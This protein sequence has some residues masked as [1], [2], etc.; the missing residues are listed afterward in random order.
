MARP[1][2]LEFPG[3]LYHV[4]SR[5]HEKSS[6]FRDRRDRRTFLAILAAVIRRERWLLH[7]YCLLGNHYHL[8]LETPLGKL[9]RG[10]HALNALYSQRFNRRHERCGHLF[11]GRFKALHVEK[12]SHLL[13]LHRY[14][15][16]NPVRA[17]LVARPEE[18]VWSSYR[19]TCGQGIAPPWLEVEWTLAQF[20]RDRETA[21]NSY[22]RFV[23]SAVKKTSDPPVTGQVYVGSP[24]FVADIAR[25]LGP[26]TPDSEIPMVQQR[27]VPPTLDDVRSTV[28][29]EWNVPVHVLSRPRT[30]EPKVAAIYLAAKLTGLAKREIGGAFGVK[31]GRVSNVISEVERGRYTPLRDRLRSLEEIINA[32]PSRHSETAEPREV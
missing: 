14:I 28:C 10:M 18:W 26:R 11:E 19:A 3:A 20:A 15:V 29:T 24:A 2:R 1:L 23:L 12:E 21:V 7:S 22:V 4:M 13:E 27:P 8:L 25:R 31:R 30:S 32:G 17:G 5:G 6:I 9:S 16:L